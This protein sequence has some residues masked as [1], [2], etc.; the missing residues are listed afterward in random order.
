MH[1]NHQWLTESQLMKNFQQYDK[2]PCLFKGQIKQIFFIFLKR[3]K[4]FAGIK[5]LKRTTQLD[6]G[7][8]CYSAK[9]TSGTWAVLVSEIWHRW[10]LPTVIKSQ[11]KSRS[12]WCSP[13]SRYTWNFSYLWMKGLLELE[14]R[15]WHR[16]STKE[17][18]HQ[19]KKVMMPDLSLVVNSDHKSPFPRHLIVP[20]LSTFSC[21][22]QQLRP[23]N[24]WKVEFWPLM[25]T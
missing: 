9:E 25:E 4:I 18:F 21:C 22:P 14:F 13:P 12:K 10:T 3:I 2:Y 17:L 24:F 1:F 11:Y 7:E 20:L 23:V 15:I 19:F 8:S 16:E 5:S 6:D